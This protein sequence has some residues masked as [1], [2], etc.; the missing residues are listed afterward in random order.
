M[1]LSNSRKRLR[2]NFIPFKA[3]S[4]I[5]HGRGLKHTSF[6]MRVHMNG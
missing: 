5:H 2:G 3:D 1:M 4:E 6:N